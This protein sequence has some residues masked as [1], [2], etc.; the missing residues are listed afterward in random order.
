MNARE[1]IL[2]AADEL[3]GEVGFDAA[4]TRQ[5]AEASGA[6][7]ALI[8]YHFQNKQE[9]FGELMDRYYERLNAALSQALLGEGDARERLRRLV[10][11]YMDFLR[12]NSS[13][14]K[15]VQRE[16]AG[17]QHVDRIVQH[18]APLFELGTALLEQA[19]PACRTGPLTATQLL[20][21]FFAMI[22]GYFTYAPAVGGLCGEDP[23]SPE[24]IEARKRHIEHIADLVIADLEARATNTGRNG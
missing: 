20:V 12:E 22:I 8:H 18:T 17:G 10:S 19:W 9:L 24:A 14:W 21:S 13:F 16:V 23:L 5:I 4:T 7:K 6:N 11:A 2:E 15:M 1:R 3:F